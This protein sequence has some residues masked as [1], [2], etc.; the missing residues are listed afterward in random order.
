MSGSSRTVPSPMQLKILSLVLG[1]RSGREVAE[2]YRREWGEPIS[3]GTLY[4]TLRRLSEAGW[5][6]VEEA[7]DADRRVRWYHISGRGVKA[8]NRGREHYRRIA[9]FKPTPGTSG[10]AASRKGRR[11]R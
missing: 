9:D 7:L 5:V 2:L 11:R 1:R 4:T 3:Y 6:N 10:R 8:M